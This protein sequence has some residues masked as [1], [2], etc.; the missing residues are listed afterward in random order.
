MDQ[1]L[2]GLNYWAWLGFL[3]LVLAGFCSAMAS[4]V[5]TSK[6]VGE[7][8][9]EGVARTLKGTKKQVDDATKKI[10]HPVQDLYDYIITIHKPLSD[11]LMGQIMSYINVHKLI[12][13][14]QKGVSSVEGIEKVSVEAIMEASRK[15][16]QKIV[17]L[18]GKYLASLKT[19]NHLF[20][21]V[22]NTKISSLYEQ[23]KTGFNV[24]RRSR[25]KPIHGEMS[26]ERF[27]YLVAYMEIIF[28]DLV[29]EIAE[30]KK[31]LLDTQQ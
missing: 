3:F 22:N 1:T 18:D 12:R 17:D 26:Y 20:T 24:V 4:K 16:G 15:V 28:N 2:F 23:Y 30:T 5:T 25:T 11:R 27:E 19:L 7:T 10:T 9:D 13:E 14:K 31:R 21:E 6:I 29:D 8:V